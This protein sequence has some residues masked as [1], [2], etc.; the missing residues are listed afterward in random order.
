MT[1][2]APGKCFWIANLAEFGGAFLVKCNYD[3]RFLPDTLPKFYK[4]CLAEWALYK[5][6]P[7]TTLSDVLNEIIWNNKFLCIN[8]KPLF[9]NKL[10][11]KGFLT[12]SDLL[13]DSGI[14]KSW[15][16]LQNQNVTCAEYFVLISVFDSFPLVWK[17]FLKNMPNNLP[18]ANESRYFIFPACSKNVFWE[19]IKNIEKP[20]VSIAKYEQLFPSHDLS[21]EDIYLLPRNASLDSKMR[22]FQYKTLNRITTGAVTAKIHTHYL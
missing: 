17:S 22:E 1:I 13:T 19:L 7:I 18:K 11:R 6:S 20:P 14:M 5:M 3:V 4:E 2:K 8:G 9:R 12:V 15:R 16:I 21:W 10:L